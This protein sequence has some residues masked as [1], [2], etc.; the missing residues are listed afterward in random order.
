MGRPT[1]IGALLPRAAGAALAKRGF[2]G[3][4]VINAWPAIVGEELAAVAAPL[5][6][7]F[8]LRRGDKATLVLQV[9]SG[10]AATLLQMKAPLLIERVNGFLG[11]GTVGR[12]E[13]RQGPLPKPRRRT[14]PGQPPLRLE[15]EARVMQ[16]TAQ[17]ASAEIKDALQRLGLAIARRS[18]DQGE[19]A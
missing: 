16:A 2:A 11:A 13:A 14:Q 18:R 9:A 7:K 15:D 3:A 10:A 1:T 8:A 4:A 19:A 12:I 6:V 17:V 5:E